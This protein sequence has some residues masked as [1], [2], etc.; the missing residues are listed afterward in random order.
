MGVRRTIEPFHL[1]DRTLGPIADDL[2]LDEALLVEAEESGGPPVLRLWEAPAPA[3]VLGASGRIGEEV[4]VAACRADGVPITRRSSGGGTVV[5]GPGALNLTV[6]LPRDF[7]EGLDAVDRAQAF[8]LGRV[9]EALK[10]RGLGV[11]VRGSGD[12]TLGGRKFAGSAQRRL[13]RY[14]LVHAS[15]LYAFPLDRIERYL[16]E[17]RRQPAYRQG[18]PH[19]EFV[20]NL[21]LGREALAG[22]IRS[23]WL[24]EEGAAPPAALPEARVRELVASKFADPAWV[25]R[26]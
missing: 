10:A 6:V 7:A 2:A 14:F 22:S 4:R 12:L 21:G 11:E 3:V 16:A 8:V 24:G 15:V 20:T 19:A 13:K 25:E 9:A 17:P 5:I 18:R 1:L 26:F 23:A